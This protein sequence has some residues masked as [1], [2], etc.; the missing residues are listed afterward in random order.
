[1]RLFLDTN[2]LLDLYCQRQGFYGDALKLVMAADAGDVELWASAK[3]F[4]DAFYVMVKAGGD[5]LGAQEA[6]LRSLE[7]IRVCSVD[8]EDVTA[9]AQRKWPDFEDCL[10][11]EGAQK[12][13]ADYLVT[14]DERGFELSAVEALSPDEL[15]KRL[16]D[17]F[18][19]IYE[20]VE[21]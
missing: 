19:I 17:D 21:L 14:R 3:S 9:A 4:S 15:F 13:G 6:F 10:I 16:E 12:V 11:S 7:L 20:E 18:G 1:M 8:E 5:P 2:V